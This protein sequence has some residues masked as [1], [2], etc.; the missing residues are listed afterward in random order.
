MPHGSPS[1]CACT[2]L[3]KAARAVGHVYDEALASHGMTTAQFAI[4]RTIV[5]GAPLPL[6]RL[7]EQLVLDRTSLYRALAPLEA[8]G[9]VAVEQGP[10]KTK[11]AALTPAG[12]AAL[13]AA[14]ADWD[15]VQA[16]I[17]GAMGEDEWAALQRGL[18][19]ITGLAQGAH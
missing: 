5:R 4:L 19:A 13:T 7:A 9:W 15:A 14:E 3:R 16:R 1:G 12:Q 17:S 2:L 18:K 6:S 11:L 10:G 8:Q